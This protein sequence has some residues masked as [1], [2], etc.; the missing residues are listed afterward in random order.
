MRALRKGQAAA[1]NITRDILAEARIVKRASGI[2]ASALGR[3]LPKR[4]SNARRLD[5]PVPARRTVS[6]AS[7]RR[8]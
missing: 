5:R 7:Q 2:G 6:C 4:R 3:G 1:F 8:L